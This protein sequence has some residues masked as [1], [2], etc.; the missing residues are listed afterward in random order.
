MKSAIKIAFLLFVSFFFLLLVRVNNAV[1][2]IDFSISSPSNT[3]ETQL[4]IKVNIA[5]L[6]NCP[7]NKCY[8]LA[9]FQ[10]ASGKRYFGETKNYEE[11]WISYE[12]SFEKEYIQ[13]KFFYFEPNDGIWEGIINVRFNPESSQYEG[14]GEYTLKAWRYTGKGKTAA[15][16]AETII[17]LQ[18]SVPI[19]TEIPPTR[20]PTDV[21][22]STPKP[23]NTP[24]PTKASTP[25]KTPTPT[26][27]KAA[28][29]Q[30]TGSVL[31]QKAKKDFDIFLPT[32]SPSASPTAELEATVAGTRRNKIGYLFIGL[33]IIAF[34][35]SIFSAYRIYKSN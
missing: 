34:F 17:Q 16:E 10:K 14:P 11:E 33:G 28:K 18:A 22:T 12:S 30:K 26:K 2:S 8:L 6:T 25:T 13:D 29:V 24:K 32:S 21:P 20:L 9:A 15:G 5:G 1:A 19:P 3:E 7:E 35:A 31:G 4:E 27:A 23:T